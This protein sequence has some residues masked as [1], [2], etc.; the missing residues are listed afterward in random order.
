MYI[1]T[2]ICYVSGSPVEARVETEFTPH[3]ART[4]Y[5]ACVCGSF[6]IRVACMHVYIHTSAL[7]IIHTVRT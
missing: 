1:H 7:P 5:V 3:C 6:A 4:S 2:H